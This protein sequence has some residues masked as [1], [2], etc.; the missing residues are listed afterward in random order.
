MGTVGYHAPAKKAKEELTFDSDDDGDATKNNSDTDSD[1]GGD[2]SSSLSLDEHIEQILR[3]TRTIA[4]LKIAKNT[5]E[6]VSPEDEGDDDDDEN[7]TFDGDYYETIEEAEEDERQEEAKPRDEAVATRPGSFRRLASMRKPSGVFHLED[8]E[9][10][11]AAQRLA[12]K[13]STYL[14]LPRVI[15]YRDLEAVRSLCY[16]LLHMGMTLDA[17]AGCRS[18]RRCWTSAATGARSTPT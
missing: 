13:L 14:C 12:R 7:D 6:I 11:A 8:T 17:D 10:A 5:A 3:K 9:E 2:D 18:R 16:L 15:S 4:L 1:G